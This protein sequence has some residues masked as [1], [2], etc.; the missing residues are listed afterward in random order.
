MLRPA[1]DQRGTQQGGANRVRCM[2]KI[3][4]GMIQNLRQC[5]PHLTV[6]GSQSKKKKETFLIFC[7]LPLGQ[8]QVVRMQPDSV[9]TGNVAQRQPSAEAQSPLQLPPHIP[10]SAPLPAEQCPGAGAVGPAR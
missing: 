8:F 7:F 2:K 9:R 6:L 10:A 5:R 4:T 1:L 3:K